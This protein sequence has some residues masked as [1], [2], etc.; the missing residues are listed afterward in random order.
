METIKLTGKQLK[1]FKKEFKGHMDLNL[2]FIECVPDDLKDLIKSSKGVKI[3]DL[4]Y[5]Y[6]YDSLTASCDF[7]N[8]TVE[9]D[10][11][12]ES[13]KEICSK[14]VRNFLVKKLTE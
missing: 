1:Q 10:L 7:L 3:D 6:V 9:K 2:A 11:I 4:L 13:K 5:S 14:W 8:Y 12:E